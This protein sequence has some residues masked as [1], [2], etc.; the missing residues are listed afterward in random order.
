MVKLVYKSYGQG[1]IKKKKKEGPLYALFFI[2][3]QHLAFSCRG[4]EQSEADSREETD[5]GEGETQ[6][7]Y[8]FFC[9]T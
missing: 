1:R 8:C 5:D 2:F 4:E 9:L 7:R 6:Q 3:K